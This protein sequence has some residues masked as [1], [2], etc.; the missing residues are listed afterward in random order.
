MGREVA[1]LLRVRGFTVA[2]EV[3]TAVGTTTGAAAG[4]AAALTDGAAA[5]MARRAGAGGALVIRMELEDGGA[6]RGT[7]LRGGGGHAAV[8]VLEIGDS[9]LIERV[10]AAKVKGAGF[11]ETS[12]GALAAAGSELVSRLVAAVAK[13]MTERWPAPLSAGDEGN[14]VLIEVRGYRDWAAIGA[15]TSQLRGNPDIRRVWPRRLGSQGVVLAVAGEL[16]RRRVAA[17][18]RRTKAENTR[19]DVTSWGENGLTVT[20]RNPGDNDS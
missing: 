9:G 1:S 10:A 6:I 7:D 5:D 11:A 8:R 4:D 13:P 2:G 20:L 14:L 3:D 17:L 19:M 12:D 15:L 18:V 16:G